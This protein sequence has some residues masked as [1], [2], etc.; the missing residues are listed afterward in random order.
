MVDSEVFISN[1]IV[2]KCWKKQLYL[3][4]KV[5]L[6]FGKKECPVLLAL[7]ALFS[8]PLDFKSLL[9]RE[10]KEWLLSLL[11]PSLPHVLFC[12]GLILTNVRFPEKETN[13]P[14]AEKRE[15]K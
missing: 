7:E 11:S 4:N 9:P 2:Q 14:I 1:T 8:G 15:K 3:K 10:A 5:R 12:R 13:S 6:P